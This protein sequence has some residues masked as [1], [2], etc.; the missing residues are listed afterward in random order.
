M[1][2]IVRSLLCTTR[3]PSAVGLSRALLCTA[4]RDIP[5]SLS[6]FVVRKPGVNANLVDG[7]R[8]AEKV[9]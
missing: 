6:D 5:P 3:S 4:S 8:L 1:S 2:C 7:K 9:C